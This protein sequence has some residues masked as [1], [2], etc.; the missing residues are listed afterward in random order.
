MDDPPRH[1]LEQAGVEDVAAGRAGRRPIAVQPRV[2]D[3][4]GLVG[5]TFLAEEPDPAAWAGVLRRAARTSCPRSTGAQG[6]PRPRLRAAAVAR[7]SAAGRAR[8]RRGGPL[9]RGRPRSRGASRPV[10]RPP[11]WP[12]RPARSRPG[13]AGARR[14]ALPLHAGGVASPS[15]QEDGAMS[16]RKYKLG[17][18]EEM[19]AAH[20][21]EVPERY[22]IASD[23]C[24][25][26]RATGSRWS[27]GLARETSAGS[28]S[29]SYRTSRTAS[30][31]VLE[32]IGVERGDRVATLLPVAAGDR[33]GLHRHLPRGAVLL[34]MSV[35]YGDEGIEH[36]L[37]DSAGRRRSSRRRQPRP[38]PRGPG[39]KGARDRR[40]ARGR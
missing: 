9:D 32:A 40:R 18:Y 22:N 13:A 19:R 1:V 5:S 21:W 12:R 39:R 29:A 15:R 35:L 25:K 23:V 30:R 16:L 24:D 8:R 17:D 10:R 38:H 6:G 3:G 4:V 31:N 27:G 26:H 11:G 34:S 14:R 36:R 33:G 7:R 2:A 28:T 20:R 37:R